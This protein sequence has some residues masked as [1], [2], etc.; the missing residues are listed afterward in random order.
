MATFQISIINKKNKTVEEIEHGIIQIGGFQEKF[1]ISTSFWSLENYVEHWK[2]SILRT[3][4]GSQ[5]SCLITS[6]Y[7]PQNAN[8]L[9]WWLLYRNKNK[10][11]IQNAILFFDQLKEPFDLKNPYTSIPP[12]EIITD[13][14]LT[15]SEWSIDI[16]DL[17]NSSIVFK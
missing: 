10:V 8:F 3:I 6:L 1:K 9:F 12:R 16:D 17:R 11:F 4:N 5:K 13:D 2:K 15:I 14:G 7:D